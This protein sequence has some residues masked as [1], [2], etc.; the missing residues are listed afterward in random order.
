MMIEKMATDLDPRVQA[1]VDEREIRQLSGRS[2]CS[3]RFL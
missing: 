1:A 2:T 3:G